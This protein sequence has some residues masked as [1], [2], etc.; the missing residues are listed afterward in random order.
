MLERKDPTSTQLTSSKPR[1]VTFP[2]AIAHE[3]QGQPSRPPVGLSPSSW[4]GFIRENVTRYDG[5]E[6]FLA[7]T[8]ERTAHA[9]QHAES[10]MKEVCCN[11]RR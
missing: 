1:P 8:T 4:Q 7:P 6:G 3:A 11:C 9:W 5:D 2:P 10:L